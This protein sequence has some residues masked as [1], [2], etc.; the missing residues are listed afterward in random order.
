M[1]DPHCFGRRS[2]SNEARLAEAW[3][4][5]LLELRRLP[6]RVQLARHLGRRATVATCRGVRPEV[7]VARDEGVG[8]EQPARVLKEVPLQVR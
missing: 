7:T 8:G 1:A 2:R 5:H 6:Q 4:V 3:P